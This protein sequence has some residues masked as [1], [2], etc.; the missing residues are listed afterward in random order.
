M[1]KVFWGKGMSR[2]MSCVG[3]L[4]AGGGRGGREEGKGGE[5]GGSDLV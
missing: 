3:V 2:L 4:G 1:K 5:G